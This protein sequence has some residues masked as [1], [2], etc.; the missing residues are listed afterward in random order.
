[1]SEKTPKINCFHCKFFIT[2]WE[3]K[4]PKGCALFGIKTT[5]MP[6]ALVFNSTGEPCNGFIKK[7]N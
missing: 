5:Q 4:Y 3:P 1:M 6:S 2:T 7:D